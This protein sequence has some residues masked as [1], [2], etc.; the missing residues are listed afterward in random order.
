MNKICVFILIL[1]TATL[2]N[3][4][5]KTL[6][7]NLKKEYGNCYTDIVRNL[8]SCKPSSCTYPDLTDARAWKAITIIG[9]VNKQCYVTYYSYIGEQITTDP[10]H[11]FYNRKQNLDLTVAYRRLFSS[12]SS[13]VIADTKDLI[14]RLTYVNC[15][16]LDS[17]AK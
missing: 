8:N 12:N 16:K 17:K 10:D 14:Q 11:C 1:L 5:S 7:D 13:V 6:Q 4:K 2:A 15:K 3:A 9:M